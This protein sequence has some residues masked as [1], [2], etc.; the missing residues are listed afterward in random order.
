M[1]IVLG[2][3]IALDSHR[4][5]ILTSSLEHVARSR[6]EP[7][8]LSHEVSTDPAN[9]NRLLFAERWRDKEALADHFALPASQAFVASLK[10]RIAAPP[11]LTVYDANEI[12]IA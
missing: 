3:I 1:L 2:E 5:A 12:S 4:E 11:E 10:G 8:C 6:Q 7:G 9:P